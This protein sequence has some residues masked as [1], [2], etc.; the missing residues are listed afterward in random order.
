LT[1]LL[2]GTSVWTAL[3]CARAQDRQ[4][5]ARVNGE[6]ITC[7]AFATIMP[8]ESGDTTADRQARQNLLDQMIVQKLL[9]QRARELGYQE[10]LAG[11]LEKKRSE[12]LR[13]ELLIYAQTLKPTRPDIARESTM[14]VTEV[15]VKLIEVSTYDTAMMVEE[16]MRRGVPFDSLVPRFNR[17]AYTDPEGVIGFIPAAGVPDLIYRVIE[18]LSPGQA[19][20]LIIQGVYYDFVKLLE[21]RPSPSAE[22]VRVYRPQI[23]ALARQRK[24]RNFVQQIRGQVTYDEEALDLI[25]RKS[26]SLSP[27]DLL[28]VVAKRPDGYKTRIGGLLPIVKRYPTVYPALKRK[29]LKEDIENDILERA[30]LRLKLD[31]AQHFRSEY[32]KAA[33]SGT[34]QYFYSRVL[35][36]REKVTDADVAAEY[37]QHPERYAQRKLEEATPEIRARLTADR[38]QQR[39]EA[40]VKELRGRARITIDRRLLA[41]VKPQKP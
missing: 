1:L 39:Y 23:E 19:S 31:R 41:R 30:A 33:T 20:R 38:R 21:R 18:K 10:T 27:E 4:A 40:L 22:S 16:L 5:L 36:D 8:G 26:D 3:A 29:A 12:L 28:R 24:A 14:F 6:A 32:E 25:T 37:E 13:A 7:R 9:V 11:A 2:T 34:Y 15:N 35:N 17:A